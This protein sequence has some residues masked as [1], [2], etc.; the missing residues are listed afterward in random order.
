[1]EN[2]SKV[3]GFINRIQMPNGKVYALKC[4]VAEV[5]P[6]VCPK[7]GSSFELKNGKGKCPACDTYFTTE[8]KIVEVN[9]N[10]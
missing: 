5:Y 1:M 6:V 10:D 4:E 9:E 8:F 2:K 7:C 3:D